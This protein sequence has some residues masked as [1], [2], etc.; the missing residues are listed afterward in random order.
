VHGLGLL[1]WSN[2]VHFDGERD[3]DDAYRG[4]LADG[5]RPGY[6]AE[7]GTALHFV[8]E[9]LARVVSSRPNARAY[10]MAMSP[11][12]VTCEPL[13]TDYLG[14]PAAEPAVA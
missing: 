11:D 5:M 1:P 6:A 14:E 2:C 7:D 9:D 8:G 13:A 10:A 12:G 3:R 4:L